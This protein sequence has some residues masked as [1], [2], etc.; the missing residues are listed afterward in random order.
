MDIFNS[1]NSSITSLGQSPSV[2]IVMAAGGGSGGGRRGAAAARKSS[3]ASK[4]LLGEGDL[5]RIERDHPQ[6]LTASEIVDIFVARGVRF[7][8]A[9][10]RKYI[11][12]G[13]IPRSRRIG[14]KGKN[15]GSLG[16]YPTK[17][18]R[19]VNSV[20]QLMGIGIHHRRNSRTVFAFY[21]CVGVDC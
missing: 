1:V 14:R 18:V 19:R 5:L 13:L 16:V 6:G 10:F 15:R 17:A 4:G 11:Q 8:E 21:R 7:S 20:K 3:A 9:T 2:G 12:Q